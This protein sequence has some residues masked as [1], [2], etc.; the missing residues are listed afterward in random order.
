MREIHINL[1]GQAHRHE[2]YPAT[3]EDRTR[4]VLVFPTWEGITD[5][6]RDIA[7]RLNDKGYSAMLI[8]FYGTETNL[9]TLQDRQRAMTPFLNDLSLLQA[10]VSAL[11][12]SLEQDFLNKEST[13]PLSVIGFCLGG[14]CAIHA[15]LQE[16]KISSAIS[17]HG[18]LK[19]PHTIGHAAQN[20]RFLII[21]GSLDPMVT[22]DEVA[23]AINFFDD[24][25]L[26]M[27]LVS[28]SGTY[29]AFMQPRA[30]SPKSG[31]LYSPVSSHRAWRLC[32]S[33]LSEMDD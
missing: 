31:V 17:F 1:S 10:K 4:Q 6:E 27:T 23:R 20:T 13:R 3:S 22:M 32:E 11:V 29:H 14:L 25:S 24:H 12:T 5:F 33:F 8:D 9:A 30:N 18:L 15:G 26:D 2:Y 21:N 7:T 16:Q 28:I 19:L